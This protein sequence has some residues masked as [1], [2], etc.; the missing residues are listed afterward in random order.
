[1]GDIEY[2]KLDP[3]DLKRQLESEA[4]KYE[5]LRSWEPWEDD[6]L[7]EYFKKVPHA[8]LAEKLKR[9]QGAV[10]Y[11]AQTLGLIKLGGR[12]KDKLIEKE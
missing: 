2:V 10:C 9:K 3:K 1:M 4:K 11:R 5:H 7:R 12:G 6:L 8:V